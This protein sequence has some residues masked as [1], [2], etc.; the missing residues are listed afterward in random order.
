[1]Y[2]KRGNDANIASE[3]TTPALQMRLVEASTAKT[4]T[5]PFENPGSTD[6]LVRNL[7]GS[8][9]PVDGSREQLIHQ[10]DGLSV[11]AG[12]LAA[13]P[14]EFDKRS[15]ENLRCPKRRQRDERWR[16]AGDIAPVSQRFQCCILN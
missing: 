1:M 11:A 7:E 12:G 10:P 8:G 4:T 6:E 9:Y 13:A 14:L 5:G 16:G 2:P 3:L 15:A